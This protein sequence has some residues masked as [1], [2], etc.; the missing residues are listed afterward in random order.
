MEF[1]ASQDT[2]TWVVVVGEASRRSKAL[3]SS[4]ITTPFPRPERPS[5]QTQ[6]H[7]KQLKSDLY[8]E[9]VLVRRKT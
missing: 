8:S 7:G 2:E 1:S 5:S 6:F 3:S 9:L 4:F